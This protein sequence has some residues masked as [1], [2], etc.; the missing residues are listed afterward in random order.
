M[1]MPGCMVPVCPGVG[2]VLESISRSSILRKVLPVS[3]IPTP[4]PR[5]CAML[6]SAWPNTRSLWVSDRLKRYSI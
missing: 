6:I 2:T 3:P 4:I 5:R 1:P